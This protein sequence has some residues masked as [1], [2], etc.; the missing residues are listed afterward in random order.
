MSDDLNNKSKGFFHSNKATV[1]FV[2]DI[3]SR[4]ASLI[5]LSEQHLHPKPRK[6][7]SLLYIGWDNIHDQ[8]VQQQYVHLFMKCSL[9][10]RYQ[11]HGALYK[12]KRTHQLTSP[13]SKTIGCFRKVIF[14]ILFKKQPSL[15][16]K[17]EVIWQANDSSLSEELHAYIYTFNMRKNQVH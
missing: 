9:L 16:L 1:K 15:L 17:W 12:I 6:P 7:V 11:H 3:V 4:K 8:Q 5:F 2:Y 14:S 13:F 10:F